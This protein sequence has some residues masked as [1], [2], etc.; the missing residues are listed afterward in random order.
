MPFPLPVED[1]AGIDP[2]AAG[3]IDMGE[4]EPP[5]GRPEL[6]PEA[7]SDFYRIVPEEGDHRR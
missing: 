4:S 5:P 7:G 1:G 2:E 3:Q 6:C